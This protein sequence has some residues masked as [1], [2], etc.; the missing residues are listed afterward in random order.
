MSEILFVCTGNTCRSS[1]AAAIATHLAREQGLEITISSA[2]IAAREGDPATAAA[3]EALAEMGID[4][5]SH[6]AQLFDA[7]KAKAVVILT[8][9]RAH[10][11]YIRQNYPDAAH[12]TFTLKEYAQGP[13][14]DPGQHPPESAVNSV[15]IPDPFGQATAFY[16]VLANELFRLVA[17]TLKK[18][19]SR[20]T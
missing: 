1:M 3:I 17:E 2:G 13:S 8:M 14:P 6:R 20:Q 11:E 18:Y 9:T 10:K 5:K 19:Q 16:R 15:D 7:A 4:L 12:R